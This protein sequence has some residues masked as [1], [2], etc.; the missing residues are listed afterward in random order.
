[1][2]KGN[3]D[4]QVTNRFMN[5]DTNVICENKNGQDSIFNNNSND[6]FYKQKSNQDNMNMF[7]DWKF[8]NTM[9]NFNFLKS[10]HVNSTNLKNFSNLNNSNSNNNANNNKLGKTLK[11]HI[12]NIC[13]KR[14][15]R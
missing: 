9:F 10:T 3:D 14:F 2:L 5:R 11:P 4:H 6:S 7:D 15:A 13:Q 8:A 1:M 12:C